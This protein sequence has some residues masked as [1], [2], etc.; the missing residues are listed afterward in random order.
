MKPTDNELEMALVA[1]KTMRTRGTDEH[2]VATALLY[3][4]QRQQDLEQVRA[5]AESYLDSGQDEVQQAELVRAIEAAREN[6]QRA[7]GMEG[8]DPGPG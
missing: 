1:A 8:R 5:A 3:L 4:Y 7:M 2:H 6:E